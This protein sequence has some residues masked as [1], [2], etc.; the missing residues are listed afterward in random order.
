LG[1]KENTYRSV[2]WKKYNKFSHITAKDLSILIK[3]KIKR[4]QNKLFVLTTDGEKRKKNWK[5]VGF[6]LIIVLI[7]FGF[8]LQKGHKEVVSL[9]S[10]HNKLV[11]L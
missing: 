9:L 11:T 3:K 7:I 2:G 10:S 1:I 5:D 4:C 8:I 6:K